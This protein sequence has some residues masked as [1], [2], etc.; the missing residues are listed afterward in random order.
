LVPLL[1]ALVR[2]GEKMASYAAWVRLHPETRKIATA[3]EPTLRHIVGLLPLSLRFRLLHPQVALATDEF[4]VPVRWLDYQGTASTIEIRAQRPAPPDDDDRVPVPAN[5]PL[6]F[7]LHVFGL[8]VSSF[9]L[10]G[11]FGAARSAVERDVVSWSEFGRDGRRYWLRLFLFLA[12]MAVLYGWAPLAF[13]R[14]RPGEHFHGPLWLWQAYALPIVSFF[15]ALT[16]CAIVSDD[17]GLWQALRRSVVTV[18]RF[19]AGGVC[20]LLLLSLARLLL[21]LPVEVTDV[22]VSVKYGF[23]LHTPLLDRPAI[24]LRPIVSALVGTWFCLTALH[25]YRGARAK[26]EVSP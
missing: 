21:R 20:L 1:L 22:L 13:M 16:W 3:S 10:G 24:M 2:G 5:W 19:A 18:G 12:V 4:A 7:G 17:T 26:I 11:F 23:R 8:A 14:H 6:R 25:W 15:L 9:I